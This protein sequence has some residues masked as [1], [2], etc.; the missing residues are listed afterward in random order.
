M[1]TSA[2]NATA[3]LHVL[4]LE[5]NADDA[6][7]VQQLLQAEWP[8]CRVRCVKSRES[9]LAELQERKFDLI[10]SDFSMPH[11]DGL[12]ALEL[13]RDRAVPFIFLSGTLGEDNAV[14]ALQRGAT[15]YVIKDRPA[16]L[17]P[18]IR[19]ALHEARIERERRK[20][21]ALI[22]EQAEYLNQARDA[23]VATDLELRIVYCNHG[24]ERVL[25]WTAAQLVGTSLFETFG[26]HELVGFGFQHDALACDEWHGEVTFPNHTGDMLVLDSRI[27]LL[28]DAA[29][30]PST[31]LIIA[32][33]VT[34][35]RLL[36]RKFLR[37]QR[38]ESIG[39]LAGGIA[40]DLNNV[41]A[42][43]LMSVNL[44]AARVP[45]PEVRRITGILETSALRGACL[46]RQI[47]AFAR[48]TTGE[49]I[50]LPL[51]SLIKEVS[52]MLG[53]TLPR[54]I[55]IETDVAQDLRPVIADGTQLSQAIMNLCVNARDAM[56]NGGRL[57]IRAI[58]LNLG[59]AIV[60][61]HPQAGAG[62][63]VLITVEDTGTGMSPEVMNH[64]F[65]PFF[66]TKGAGKGT[67]LGLSTVLGIVKGH[68]GFIDVQS[69]IGR[70]TQFSLYLPAAAGTVAATGEAKSE[71]FRGN[72]ETILVIDDETPI[73][74][75]LGP[76][77]EHFGYRPLLAADGLEGLSLFRTR[78]SEISVVI[79]DLMMPTMQG[80][81]VIAELREIDPDVRIVAM[82]GAIDL[83][84]RVEEIPGRL[85]LLHKPVTTER[86]LSVLRSVLPPPHCLTH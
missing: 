24:A 9:F 42:P 12:S 3:D 53:E 58:N 51:G 13:A 70:G 5:D 29:G 1:N 57:L 26:Q 35:Q 2:D 11:F 18:A 69:E 20:A 64:I 6:E 82:S 4:H 54:S 62:P 34:E 52:L 61:S 81:E 84:A 55:A 41:L 48:G 59:A 76:V 27:T 50:E 25:G 33:D 16:R 38:L 74:E 31:H 86:L 37:T 49:R 67:G 7:L 68:G 23:I 47:L 14:H 17:I 56:P 39:I 40:H 79:T 71:L 19:R 85:A 43:V 66:T 80:P 32:T 46:V 78:R 75:L 30:Q 8:A 44:I 28:R 15:D 60:R 22:R 36:E 10:L 83:Q 73:R 45:D 63:H 77:L 65:E 72:G 21:E